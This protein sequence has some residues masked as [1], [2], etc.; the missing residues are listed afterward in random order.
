M[1]PGR[2]TILLVEDDPA[3]RSVLNGML[4][5][6]GFEV[7]VAQ[8]GASALHQLWKHGGNLSLLVTDIDMG[9]MGGMELAEMVRSQYPALPILFISGLPIPAG[10]LE[11]SAPGTFLL[12]K[13]FGAVALVQ[14]VEK[15]M[16]DPGKPDARK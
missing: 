12:A 7:L 15:A 1:G 6:A 13:P 14:A 3:V 2:K 4:T 8:D 9:R 5:D 16:T 10:E 11:S